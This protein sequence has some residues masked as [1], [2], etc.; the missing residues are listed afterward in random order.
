MTTHIGLP[1]SSTEYNNMYGAE[2]IRRKQFW[3]CAGWG[4][5]DPSKPQSIHSFVGSPRSLLEYYRTRRPVLGDRI[6]M[7]VRNNGRIYSGR[8][9]GVSEVVHAWAANHWDWG[10][11][12]PSHK[13]RCEN[14]L[15]AVRSA[16]TA[17]E[18]TYWYVYDVE[19]SECLNPTEEQK[20]WIKT[21]P[22]I[23][24]RNT[25]PF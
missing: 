12:T 1:G 24:K 19:W 15:A 5:C 16:G 11:R 7:R 18:E 20:N 8:V 10:Y 25:C 22:A 4:G 6:F 23:Q 9:I 21:R 17:P 14:Y 2:L 13:K 3:L